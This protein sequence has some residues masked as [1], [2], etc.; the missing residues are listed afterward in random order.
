MTKIQA[1]LDNAGS[2][3]AGA[4]KFVV[5]SDVSGITIRSNVLGSVAVTATSDSSATAGVVGFSDSTSTGFAG[6]AAVVTVDGQ[7]AAISAGSQ[8]LN[9]Q[10]NYGG[11]DGITFNIAVAGG[12]TAATGSTIISVAD[13][14]LSF[15]IGANANEVAKVSIDKATADQLGS[16]VS[17]LSNTN[18]TNL[19][20]INVTTAGGAQDAIKVI[21]QAINDVSS[22]RGKLGAF[23]A[24]TLESNANNLRAALENTTAAESIIRDTDFA[25]EIANFTKLQTQLQ[26]GATVLG[27]ANQI[28]SLVTSLLRG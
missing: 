2:V 4:G 16:G 27:N 3:G 17:G 28:T 9:N 10:V 14:S 19:S 26:A 7:A 18:T 13:Q 12:E 11:A 6:T 24:N 1:A 15:Q 23:Q 21:D 25:S 20:L 5:S 22:I 8:G